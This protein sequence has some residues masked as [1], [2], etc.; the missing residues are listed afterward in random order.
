M[1]RETI[2]SIAP[3]TVRAVAKYVLEYVTVE[4][5]NGYAEG[6]RAVLLHRLEGAAKTI[7]ADTSK[8][9]LRLSRAKT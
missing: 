1:K 6:A 4:R 3:S 7:L 9:R 5:D 2:L 8:R